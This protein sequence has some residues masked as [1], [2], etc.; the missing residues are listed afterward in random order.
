MEKQKRM[1]SNIV[2]IGLISLFI[3]MSAGK[4]YERNADLYRE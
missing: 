4:V 2:L 3:D 1:I